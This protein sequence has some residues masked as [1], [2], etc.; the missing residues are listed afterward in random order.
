MTF[1]TDILR[2][3]GIAQILLLLA[4][5]RRDRGNQQ[6]TLP[7]LLFGL[8]IVGYL[9]ADWSPMQQHPVIFLPLLVLPFLAPAAFWL[10]SKSL[11]DDSYRWRRSFGWLLAGVAAVKYFEYFQIRQPFLPLP[12]SLELLLGW[13]LQ[14]ISIV[15]IL[16]GI[17][18][19]ARNREADLVQSRLQFRTVFIVITAGLMALTVL[20][21]VSLRGA[22]PPLVLNVAQKAAILGLTVF[23]FLRLLSFKPGFFSEI[24]RPAP[25]APTAPELDERLLAQLSDL[26]DTQKYWRTEGLTI[27]Q[28]AEKMRVKEYRLRQAINQHLGY[29]NFNDY[30]NCYRVREACAVLSD[31]NKRDLTVLEIAYDLGYA[32]LAPFNKAFKDTT[33][34]TPTEWRR[35]KMS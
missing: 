30:L 15:F 1:L 22:P 25:P 7:I 12:G 19:A 3:T 34:M 11:F 29:R 31:P 6:S 4:L 33:G 2:F 32:S 24:E 35:S 20:S 28:L 21:E 9:L 5:F 13:L 27:R 10:F 26:M 17:L 23:F 18:E 16:L 14:L 8:C